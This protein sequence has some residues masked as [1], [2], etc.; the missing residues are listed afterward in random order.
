M[1]ARHDRDAVSRREPALA[2]GI[3]ERVGTLVELPVAQLAALVDQ[4]DVVAVSN[5]AGRDRT[6]QQPISLE[7]EHDLRDSVGQRRSDH[8][9]ADAHRREIRLV[10][11]ASDEP[12]RVGRNT[13]QIEVHHRVLPITLRNSART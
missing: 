2:P 8:P 3:G 6:A 11:K 5:R 10:A 4:R 1:V 9:A 12:Q 7:R 13:F